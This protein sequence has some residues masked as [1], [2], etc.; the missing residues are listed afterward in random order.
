MARAPAR[1]SVALAPGAKRSRGP[2]EH[3]PH[4]AG[5]RAARP[6]PAGRPSARDGRAT[7]LDDPQAPGRR[8][9]LARTIDVH[10]EVPVLALAESP[11]CRVRRR[12]ERPARA[13]RC[14]EDARGPG[15]ETE[16][17]GV[18][19]RPRPWRVLLRRER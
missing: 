3:P 16:R 18:D 6:R 4:A 17:H 11:P 12:S 5:A 1:R 2:S 15:D 13:S 7:D 8:R 19:L 9:T 10:T 14:A